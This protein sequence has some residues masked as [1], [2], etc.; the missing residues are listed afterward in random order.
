MFQG[1]PLSSS[2]SER[3]L[4]QV[5]VLHPAAVEIHERLFCFLF[6]TRFL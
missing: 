4:L 1:H 6:V 3:K 2:F 5:T